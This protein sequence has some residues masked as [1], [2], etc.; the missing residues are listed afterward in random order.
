M[1]RGTE[2]NPRLLALLTRP[3]SD[4]PALHGRTARL[5]HEARPPPA[6]QPRGRACGFVHHPRRDGT[7]IPAAAAV[8]LAP[9][10]LLSPPTSKGR[11]D[12]RTCPTAR[13]VSQR[14]PPPDDRIQTR[15]WKTWDC[16]VRP[17]LQ[18][19]ALV[20]GA[21]RSCRRCQM[22]GGFVASEF[23]EAAARLVASHKIVVQVRPRRY[24]G[25][26]RNAVLFAT[27]EITRS[28]IRLAPGLG[29]CHR[30]VRLTAPTLT[31]SG[32]RASTSK[33]IEIDTKLQA[34]SGHAPLWR[35]P[36]A[37]LIDEPNTTFDNAPYPSPLALSNPAD[38]PEGHLA[39]RSRDGRIA[40]AETVAAAAA[41][42]AGKWRQ[43]SL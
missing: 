43:R 21:R 29:R 42:A 22:K 34:S 11:R 5:K 13:G 2:A 7:L 8:H 12:R 31:L 14:G 41:A 15:A 4:P 28:Q 17:S 20:S 36:Y 23:V 26:M 9:V 25:F 1:R 30:P 10:C 33:A 32:F 3:D 6:S 38:E 39:E 18:F 40:N 19:P 24:R 37:R 35:Q 16:P 27:S